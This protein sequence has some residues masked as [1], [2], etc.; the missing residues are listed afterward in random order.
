[1]STTVHS[2]ATFFQ[3]S[4]SEPMNPTQTVPAAARAG[5][6]PLLSLTGVSKTFGSVQA[7]RDLD[8][9]I[10]P[11]EFVTIVGP[12]GCGK[13]TLFNIVAGLEEPDAG[14]RLDFLGRE[15]KARDLLGQVSFMPQRDLLLPWRTVIDNA[16]LAVEMEGMRRA[17]ARRMALDMLPEF[18][19]AGFENQYP[20]QLS[21]GM[22]QRVAL[23]RTFMFKRDLLLLDEPF[24]ALDALTRTMMQR[25]LLDVWQKH[26]RTILFITHDVDEA[27]FLGD[28]V[29]AMS[30]RPGRVKLELTV[31]LPRPRRPD[32]V[33]SPDFIERKRILLDAI[34]EES[35]KSFMS[36]QGR[37]A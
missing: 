6:K 4:E 14:G 37:P 35:M 11:G 26:R 32:I 27:L 17:D 25:W 2:A 1:M 10:A 33:T 7:L 18:G 13:S 9:A 36:T 29:L 22:R 28:R 16:I 20:H 24:G 8:V 21:G 15:C 23:M 30:A 34:E 12:S 19:L 3:S 31:D 5:A